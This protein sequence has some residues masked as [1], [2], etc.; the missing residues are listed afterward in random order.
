MTFSNK[1]YNFALDCINNGYKVI[2]LSQN[3]VPVFQSWCDH[4]I[5]FQE[6]D[7]RAWE[8][9][10]PFVENLALSLGGKEEYKLCAFDVD[11]EDEI[12]SEKI[13]NNIAHLLPV[14]L[15]RTRTHSNR[16][17]VMA[18][19]PGNVGDVYRAKSKSIDN[20]CIEFY[21]E[22]KLISIYGTHR[23]DEKSVYT[24]EKNLSPTEVMFDELS[25]LPDS[26]NNI[27]LL[28]EYFYSLA[29]DMGWIFPEK[30]KGIIRIRKGKE[31]DSPKSF[32]NSFDNSF[33]QAQE[34][35]NTSSHSTKG[36]YTDKEIEFILNN[37]DGN[38]YNEWLSVG[39]CFYNH[40]EGSIE[41]ALKWD[42]WSKGFP[43][44]YDGIETILK[45]YSTF[46]VRGGMSFDKMF[47]QL[48]KEV[49]I[50]K[51]ISQ[52]LAQK[53]GEKKL[54]SPPS[55][56][57]SVV[58]NILSGKEYFEYMLKNFLFIAKGPGA[59]DEPCIV[60]L[61]KSDFDDAIVTR[62]Q[63]KEYWRDIRATIRKVNKHGVPTLQE[64][65]VFDLWYDH[66]E[67][68]KAWSI[69][70]APEKQ[71]VFYVEDRQYYNSFIPPKLTYTDKRDKVHHFL[72]HLAYLFPIDKGEWF[73]N[74][75]AQIVQ[76]PHIRYRTN[77]LSVS[78]YEGTGRGWLT[79]LLSKL[80]G[81]SNFSTVDDLKGIVD[82]PKNHYLKNS[83]L[84]VFN[85]VYIPKGDK[86]RILSRLK[87]YLSD[88]I[89]SIDEKYGKQSFNVR[90]YCRFFFQS[91][92]LHGLPIDREDTRIQPFIN[93]TPPR[94]PEYYS[95]IYGLLDRDQ[96][97]INQV[98][99]YL[100]GVPINYDW[101]R[102]SS[103]T[104]DRQT[105][106]RSSVSVTSTA[107]GIFRD[108]VGEDA[109]FTDDDATNFVEEFIEKTGECLNTF[110]GFSQTRR[111][112]NPSEFMYLKERFFVDM[113][114]IIYYKGENV[115][116]RSFQVLDN[117]LT[118]SDLR[119]KLE[120][121]RKRIKLA[122]EDGG[123]EK[124]VV[125]N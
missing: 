35:F 77:P 100:R 50:P 99:S 16:F 21:T 123:Y 55:S 14:H 59:G 42:E 23:K 61:S 6:S 40:Y 74:W 94:D 106:L 64:V 38:D 112:F 116:L 41:G 88:D 109:V 20:N 58:A 26:P 107:F 89:Q 98:Y 27:N 120:A 80:V 111:T 67:R 53:E 70:Y 75:L 87:T 5:V 31:S 118:S 113:P 13:Y 96:D 9:A 2:P 17:A 86:Q 10:F 46:S 15:K 29:K 102:R 82:N 90:I 71:K 78:L 30:N 121:T 66:P 47:K 124:W 54:N 39:M 1:T 4:N 34:E 51:E 18:R 48:T 28:F 73:I 83:L 49:E 92:R 97:F 52:S 122:I 7:V 81:I 25:I 103:N 69:T 3:G 125:R 101:L 37:L 79:S 45:K 105:I 36:V 57:E 24:F 56:L 115:I 84:V 33:D 108:I 44:K 11:I 65:P 95:T 85:E 8:Q 12:V 104:P 60:D 62:K 19:V 117:S 43:E 63:V 72:N 119:E 93:R 32:Y 91:N 68:R 22:K 76:E 110:D 114:P